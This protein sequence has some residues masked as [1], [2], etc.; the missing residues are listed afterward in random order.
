[1][2]LKSL[3]F[4]FFHNMVAADLA[5]NTFVHRRSR[6]DTATVQVY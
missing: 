5:A 3:I 2:E 6:C 1:M 4:H